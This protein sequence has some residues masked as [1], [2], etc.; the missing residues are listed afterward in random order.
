MKLENLN[1]KIYSILKI[2]SMIKMGREITGR[3]DMTTQS[4]GKMSCLIWWRGRLR[5]QTPSKV[6][7]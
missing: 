4:K 1:L 6:S 2:F 7:S 5:V 3:K